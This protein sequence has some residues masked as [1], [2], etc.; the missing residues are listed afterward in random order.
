MMRTARWLPILSLLWLM[1]L[2]GCSQAQQ[3]PLPDPDIVFGYDK[4]L[5]LSPKRA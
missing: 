1:G 4:N 5:P 2:A 3:N